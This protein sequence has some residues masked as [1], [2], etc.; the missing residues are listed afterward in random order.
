MLTWLKK[1][2]KNWRRWKEADRRG[3]GS[4]GRM[5]AYGREWNDAKWGREIRR[6]N[7]LYRLTHGHGNP[8]KPYRGF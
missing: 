7:R 3:W 5:F 2:W 8:W 1:Q 4:L 6:S